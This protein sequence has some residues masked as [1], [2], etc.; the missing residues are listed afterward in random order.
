MHSRV[1]NCPGL[2]GHLK[3]HDPKRGSIL[4]ARKTPKELVAQLQTS[5]LLNP[6][7][8]PF[9]FQLVLNITPF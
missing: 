6:K 3:R 4:K 1:M 2:S 9:F 7:L 5:V 8:R